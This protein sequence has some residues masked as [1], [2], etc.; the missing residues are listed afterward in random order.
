MRFKPKVKSYKHQRQFVQWYWRKTKNDHAVGS[1]GGAAFFDPGTGKTKTAYDFISAGYAH[2]KIRRVLVLCPINAIQVW[3]DQ[4]DKHIKDEIPF[5]VIIPEGKIAEKTFQVSNWSSK[6]RELDDLIILVL[7]YQAIIK[8]D[9]A[10]K[11][12]KALMDFDPDV[13]VCDESHH[14]KNATTKQSKAAHKIG[15]KA[16]HVILLTGT[17]IGKNYLDLYSQLKAIDPDIWKA[18]WTKTGR[19]SWTDFRTNYA[20]WGG[21]TGY[22]IKGYINLDDLRGRY[23]PHI[24]SARK[25]DIHDMPKVTDQIIPV[26]MN[27]TARR[28]YNVFAEEGLVVHK[29][30]LIEAPIPLTKLLRLQQMTGGWV[31]DEHGESVEIQR[32]K[33]SVLA[34]LL[35]DLFSAGQS[36]VVFARFLRE[37]E[38][39]SAISPYRWS[40][41]IQGGVSH[42]ERRARVESF[43]RGDT[44]R[45]LAVQVAAA[46]ALDGLQTNCSYGIFY[47]SDYSL[48]HWNQARGRLDRV[49]QKNPVTFYHLQAKGTVD[50]LILGALR[51]K[52][53][54]ERVVMDNPEILLAR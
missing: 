26:E 11:I 41:S 44:P 20:M 10:W 8:R 51:D 24:R 33:I 49:G 37:L 29:R 12:M 32:D 21:R 9:Q 28:V 2:R 38:E 46:E 15:G 14:I 19:M 52:K 27:A 31:N 47:S 1:R 50:S 36:V 17:P 34:D 39:I 35:A 23:K 45:M 53:D 30:H 4:A 25:E 13:V 18:P 48:V 5:R 7:N 42:G 16:D 40:K 54:I 6:A 22:E 43:A 3:D